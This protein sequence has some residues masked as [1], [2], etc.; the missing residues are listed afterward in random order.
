MKRL[1]IPMLLVLFALATACQES[2]EKRAERDAQNLMKKC[3][4]P[5]GTDG[6][7]ILESVSFDI[8]TLTWHEV[9]LLDYGGVELDDTEVRNMLAKELKNTPSYK[10]YRDNGYRFQY[11]YLRMS[12]PK[13]TLI[14][15][16]LT[17]ADY[18]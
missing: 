10:P 9:L 15:V 1:F 12:D 16:M 13:D 2:M 14:N 11:V 18:E 3:P 4:M 8:P 17:K 6:N 5:I 7:V